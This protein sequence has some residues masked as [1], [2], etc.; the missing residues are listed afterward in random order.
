MYDDL[1]LIGY[2]PVGAI[3]GSGRV[4]RRWLCD[5]FNADAYEALLFRAVDGDN[6]N[7]TVNTISREYFGGD[8]A[9]GKTILHVNEVPAWK[10][11]CLLPDSPFQIRYEWGSESFTVSGAGYTWDDA[12]PLVNTSVQPLMPMSVTQ[13]VL[14]GTRSTIDLG[15]Y[16]AYIDKLNS[17]TFLG[18][19]AE[20][21]LFC[22]AS[23][24]PRMLETGDMTNDVEICLK[25]RR[26]SW[27]KFWN[28][29]IG[30]WDYIV[31]AGT[32]TKLLGTTSFTGLLT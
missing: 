6:P 3:D 12:S 5:S 13:I 10:L 23:A 22:G 21:V 7:F 32:S 9:T 1:E 18:A 8:K 25:R 30:D 11:L 16:D 14:F 31:Q 20:C 29:T 17:G 28:E 15:T 27:N 2:D 4:Y 19:A 24:T 26:V